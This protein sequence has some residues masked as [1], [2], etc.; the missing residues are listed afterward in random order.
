[1]MFVSA[2]AVF[3]ALVCPVAVDPIAVGKVE[4]LADAAAPP[5][6]LLPIMP[7]LMFK[8][9]AALPAVEAPLTSVDVTELS[10]VLTC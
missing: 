1:M 4:R 10:C 7:S 6:H 8:Q 2:I 3:F 9:P 5:P